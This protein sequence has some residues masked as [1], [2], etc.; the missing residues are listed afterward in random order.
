MNTEL[1]HAK[2]NIAKDLGKKNVFIMDFVFGSPFIDSKGK[3]IGKAKTVHMSFKE[4]I[5][6]KDFIFG[7]HALADHIEKTIIDSN[8]F[9]EKLKIVD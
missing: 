3:R 6:P 2:F 4:G 9:K 7:L 5:P 8:D 1:V